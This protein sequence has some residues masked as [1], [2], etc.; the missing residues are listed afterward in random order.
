MDP[1]SDPLSPNPFEC[2]FD[3][4][5]ES[6]DPRDAATAARPM[7]AAAFDA[8]PRDAGGPNVDD[9]GF[10]GPRE[11]GIRDGGEPDAFPNTCEVERCPAGTEAPLPL[12][13]GWVDGD[14]LEQ[15]ACCVLD[16]LRQPTG[17]CGIQ[18]LDPYGWE[19]R[20]GEPIVEG[21]LDES[22]LDVVVQGNVVQGCRRPDGYCGHYSPGWGCHDMYRLFWINPESDPLA[23]NPF[24]CIPEEQ[25]CTR[26]SQCCDNPNYGSACYLS[27]DVDW[28]RLP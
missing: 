3:G 18:W 1:E 21:V 28:T 15:R 13:H 5:G 24:E 26:T 10:V 6:A 22:C 17:E 16:D 12:P 14:Q 19:L 8:A 20:C 9:A 25:S 23:P 11:A 27:D 4:G 2:T 7:D